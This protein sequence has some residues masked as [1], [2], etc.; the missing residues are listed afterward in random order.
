MCNDI[1]FA[2]MLA[3]DVLVHVPSD[4]GSVV[5]VPTLVRLLSLQKYKEVKEFLVTYHGKNTYN[6]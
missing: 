6:G 3:P 2:G 5:T 1:R 4:R